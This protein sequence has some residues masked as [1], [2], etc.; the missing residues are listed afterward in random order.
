VSPD[1]GLFS[2]VA[3]LVLAGGEGRRLGRPKAFVEIGGETMLD[4]TVRALRDGGCWDV[5]VVL[6][7]TGHAEVEG[8]AVVV[9][10]DW[11]SGMGSSVR[12][13]LAA[14]EAAPGAYDAVVVMP[15]DTPGIGP[16]VVARL[17]AACRGGATVAVA[18]YDGQPRNPVLLARE[19][20]AGVSRLAVG[21][22]GAR[23]Y[24]ALHPELVTPVECGDV[25]DPADI[26][27]PDELERFRP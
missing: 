6:G 12:T 7:A 5:T 19:H 27:T 15:V 18:T 9:N 22:V 11:H 2:P 4:R 13:G 25:A 17:V 23:A 14:L 20:W 3:G 8:A 16:E 10:D 26:D 21:D 24:L 1:R